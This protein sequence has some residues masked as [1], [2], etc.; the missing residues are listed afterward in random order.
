PDYLDVRNGCDSRDHLLEPA[1]REHQRIDAG[2]NRLSPLG[3]RRDIAERGVELT[4]RQ[5]F[6]GR[7]NHLAPEAETAIDRADMGELEQYTVGI[8]V[9]NAFDRTVRVVADR[10]GPLL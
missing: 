1:G 3:M 10:V 6:S 4:H 5:G 8:A 2:Q 7:A 9:H